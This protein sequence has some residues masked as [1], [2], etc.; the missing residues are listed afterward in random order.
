MCPIHLW[1]EQPDGQRERRYGANAER[2]LKRPNNYQTR[3]QF[4]NMLI[5]SVYFHGNGYAVAM[6]DD[7][8]AVSELHLLDP[9]NTKGV[10]DPETG[11]VFYWVSPKPGRLEFVE[12]E[13]RIYPSRDILNVRINTNYSDPLKGHTPVTVA[14]NAIAANNA[15]T[16]H[17]A[18]FFNNMSRPSGALSTDLKL[19]QE[20]MTQLRQAWEKQSKG[21]NSGRIPILS[22]GLKWEQMSISSQDAQL[23]EAFQMTVISISRVFRVPPPVLNDLSGMT[24]ANTEQLMSWFLSSGLGLLLEHIEL[25][26]NNLFDLNFNQYLNF[27]T[28]THIHT[29]TSAR[30]HTHTHTHTAPLQLNTHTHTTPLQPNTHTHTHN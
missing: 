23:V 11:D 22:N 16:G 25:E 14:A 20:Q 19:T 15:I 5:R 4:F 27:E 3:S 8:R 24:Y 2:V 9:R 21:M 29:Y 30:T 18:S 6:R 28:R 26:L 13:D 17:Q 10:I 12:G 1:E 7:R